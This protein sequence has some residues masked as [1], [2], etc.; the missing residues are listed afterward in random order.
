MP[1][2]PA[3]D[4]ALESKLAALRADYRRTLPA[5]LD[6][7]EA[8]LAALADAGAPGACEDAWQLA[9]RVKGTSGSHGFAALA[10]ELETIEA[11]LEPT[12]RTGTAPGRSEQELA[13]AALLRA[14]ASLV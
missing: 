2:P 1:P 10:A 8:R 12:R 6:A 11:I 5:Q 14:R 9:H 13:R 3:R 7:L 4:P